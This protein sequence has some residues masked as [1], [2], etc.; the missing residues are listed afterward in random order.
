MP[1]VRCYN[2]NLS[3][4]EEKVVQ[5]GAEAIKIKNWVTVSYESGK[6][7]IKELGI[8]YYKPM[9]RIIEFGK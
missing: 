3:S 6:R 7:E 8:D 9:P 5:S 4:G 1:V 2:P